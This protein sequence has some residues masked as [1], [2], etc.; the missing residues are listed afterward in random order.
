MTTQV[1]YIALSGGLNLIDSQLSIPE[2]MM[3]ECLNY[4]Q[5][6]GKQGYS[7]IDGYERYD[8]R[9]EPHLAVYYVQEFDT[10]T[11]AISVGNIVTGTSA[12]GD[13]LAV[14]L[15]TGSWVGGDAAGR[16]IIGNVTGSWANNDNIQVSASTKALASAATYQGSISETLDTTY[17]ALAV[18]DRRA[19]I[20]KPTGSGG[21]LGVGVANDVVYCVRNAS[22]G[23][24]AVLYKATG[25]GWTSVKSG[26]R[27]NGVVRMVQANFS[28][29]STQLHLFGVDGVNRPWKFDGTTFSFMAP[30]YGSQATSTSS[31]AVGTGAKVFTAVQATRSWQAGDSLII[32]SSANAANYMIGTVTSYAD[33]T[34]TMNIT[35]TGGSGTFTD[36]EI[37]KA[38]FSDKP[39]DLTAHRD[40]LFLCYPS[41]Q[42]Q[43][44]NL[45]DPMV[46]TSTAALIGVGDELT[47]L[48]SMKGGVLAI[49]CDEH[50]FLLEGSGKASWSLTTN[51]VSSGARFATVQ[52]I[53][54]SVVALDDRGLTSL[55]ATQNF[56][57]FEMSIFSRMVKPYLD[58]MLPTII[59]SRVVRAKN[60]Y[61]IY[62]STGV[63]LTFTILT[64]NS[65]I[66]PRDVAV[67]RSD[68]SANVSC[69]GAGTIN[70]SEVMFF[71]T[72]DGWV[73]R[74][75][76]GTSFDGV[77]IPSVVRLPF[78]S[79]KS[80]SNKKRFRKLVL[81]LDAPSQTTINYR[82]LFDYADGN[83]TPSI[84]FST[85]V[86]GGGGQWDVDEWDTFLWSMP[87]QT[88]AEANVSGVGR[89]MSL[90]IWH[91]SALDAPFN[92]QG[93]LVHYSVLGMAR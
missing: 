77:E 65:V 30:I 41:G 12:T 71:G 60:Q 51:S 48:Q 91:E 28:G 83:Y 80:P 1:K 31:L 49:Y 39:F 15:E 45:G 40:H 79:Y 81:E 7:R 59:G 46:Y 2:G 53:A 64:P 61:R 21:I 43:T 84:N 13:V 42:L 75:D 68:Y 72:S 93:I 5:V 66:E 6:F 90:L 69:V 23:L 58:A 52:E 26:L 92:L 55:Q 36:W 19:A 88:Q 8:G 63:L 56:G 24:S 57:S 18:E 44:S 11:A 78:Y 3:T 47:G 67:T 35:S 74:E 37:G 10:G 70:N 85:D 87:V 50:T 89:N 17:Q 62:S 9:L 54:S 34:L 29:D 14:E 82:Q 22:D 20:Q 73:M 27:P 16:L 86:Q 76:V 32:W 33:P 4:E 25:S 38:D